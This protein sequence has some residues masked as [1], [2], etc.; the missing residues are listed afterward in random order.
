VIS[1]FLKKKKRK[2]FTQSTILK[3]FKAKCKDCGTTEQLTTHHKNSD[4]SDDSVK[5]LEILC[6]SC[7]RKKEGIFYKKGHYR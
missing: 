6:L 4:P 2:R 1:D 5:N 3:H 7:H